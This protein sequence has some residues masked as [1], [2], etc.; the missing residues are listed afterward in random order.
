MREL[1]PSH[2]GELSPRGPGVPY[3][4]SIGDQ[5]IFVQPNAPHHWTKSIGPREI[6]NTFSWHQ[7]IN[8]DLAGGLIVT[9]ASSLPVLVR[10]TLQ[11][12]IPRKNNEDLIYA[13][14]SSDPLDRAT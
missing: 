14:P 2:V 6:N 10:K 8:E 9:K 4:C 11:S 3:C 5:S 1:L 12:K 13:M 7:K